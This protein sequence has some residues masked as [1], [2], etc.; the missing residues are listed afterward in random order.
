MSDQVDSLV[1]FKVSSGQVIVLVMEDS[2]LE[3]F[4]VWYVNTIISSEETI[5]VQRP[6]WVGFLRLE[7]NRCNGVGR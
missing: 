2:K 3:I 7:V 4:G 6:L 5:G 1:L